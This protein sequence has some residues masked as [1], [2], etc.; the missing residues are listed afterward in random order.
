[1]VRAIRSI[2]VVQDKGPVSMDGLCNTVISTPGRVKAVATSVVGT[3]ARGC[4]P[5]AG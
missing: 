3:M 5:P 1:M 2:G 4:R